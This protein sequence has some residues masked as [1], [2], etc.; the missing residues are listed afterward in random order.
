MR[1]AERAGAA[2]REA[3]VS[4]VVEAQANAGEFD[5]AKLIASRFPE[6]TRE[7]IQEQ[8]AAGDLAVGHRACKS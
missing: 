5:A 3:L 4:Q 7:A 6:A 2:D 1:V 8:T